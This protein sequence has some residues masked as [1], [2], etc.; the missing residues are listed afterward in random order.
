MY[1][2]WL[3]TPLHVVVCLVKLRTASAIFPNNAKL[4][5]PIGSKS[6]GGITD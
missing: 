3:Y 5:R 1:I 6:C 4:Q 2:V